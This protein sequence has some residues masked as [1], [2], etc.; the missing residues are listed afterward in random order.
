M[1]GGQER[2]AAASKG[3]GLC[4][5]SSKQ[6]TICEM[7]HNSLP[8]PEAVPARAQVTYYVQL[9]PFPVGGE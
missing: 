2:T 6:S 7:M 5:F 8:V 9:A 3:K 1:A 4:L